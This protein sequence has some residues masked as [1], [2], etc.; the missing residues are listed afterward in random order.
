M[1][2]RRPLR[3]WPFTAFAVLLFM[4]ACTGR[5]PETPPP[6]GEQ[7]ATTAIVQYDKIHHPQLAQRGIVVSQNAR[8]SQ[9]GQAILARGGNATDAAIATAFALAVTL[10]RAG[11][12]GGSGFYLGY[13]RSRGSI[14]ALDFRSAAPAA[15]DPES[16]R[17][18]DGIIDRARF[19]FGPI[20]A[21]VPGT[22]AGLHEAWQRHGQ[23]PWAELVAPAE[24][25]A[26]EGIPVSAD[27]AFALNAANG[28]LRQYPSS[29]AAY[30]NDGQPYRLGERLQQPALAEALRLI[31]AEGSATLYGGTLGQR[32]VAAVQR[33]GGVLQLSDLTRYRVRE[34]DTLSTRYRDH[35]VFSM[36]PVS[37]GGATLLQMLNILSHF[38]LGTLPRGGAEHLHLLAEVM[39]QGAASRRSGLGDP[40]FAELQLQERLSP[41]AAQR[42][43]RLIRR[44][45]A[46]AVSK[47]QPLLPPLPESRDTTHLSVVDSDGNAV[48]LTYTL[49]YSFG[50]GYVAGDTG[51]LLDNQMLN[52]YYDEPTHANAFAPGKRMMST[53]SPTIV[54]DP[55]GQLFLVTGTPGGSRI[56]N[57]VLQ[58]LVNAIDYGL[59]IAS[60]T[61]APRIHQNWQ[62]APSGDAPWQ[63]PALQVERTLSRDVRKALEALGHRVETTQTIGSTQSIMVRGGHLEGAADTRRPD[64]R[65]A[66][67]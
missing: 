47:V 65:A 14:T 55:Q 49:G 22:V 28:L 21:G 61:Q 62:A 19:R 23:L 18:A 58:I 64:A 45:R 36:P 41:G 8:A 25:L 32:L 6:A 48:A 30:L 35:E 63:P 13:E 56:V 17:D 43:S 59:D 39:K 27:L 67:Y 66:G 54:L 52:F 34:R 40:D 51:I 53:M 4:T 31:G 29:T 1:I 7:P 15:F 60:A 38:E 50:S 44:D 9:I 57:A 20:S 16:F 12:L 33:D 10:P 24:Q 42:W 11:N 37:G 5:A 26:R 2:E 3:P 46:R